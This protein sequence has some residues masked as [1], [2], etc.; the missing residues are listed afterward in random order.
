MVEKARVGE[1]NATEKKMG[2]LLCVSSLGII[3]PG[4]KQQ[5]KQPES[6]NVSTVALS[7]GGKARE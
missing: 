1:A 2:M 7:A 6:R 3:G 5:S 4:Q